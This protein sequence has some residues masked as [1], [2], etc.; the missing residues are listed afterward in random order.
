M[1][2]L[3]PSPLATDLLAARAALAPLAGVDQRVVLPAIKRY[4]GRFYEAGAEGLRNAIASGQPLLIL[5]GG[6]GLLLPEEAI[7][8]YDREFKRGDWPSGL[9]EACLVA[10]AERLGCTGVS[11]FLA[12]T[13][14]YADVIRRT[15]WDS[16]ALDAQLLSPVVG[17]GEGAQVLVP[18]ALGEALS[19]AML[20]GLD[21]GWSSSDGVSMQAI[22]LGA[23][24]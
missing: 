2:D 15:R 5:S 23:T 19:A 17:G 11:A 14:G 12:S 24:A 1:L 3:L 21:A 6:Y 18:R 16:R 4:A 22:A 9:I 20:G 7:G 13:T 10:V 8:D